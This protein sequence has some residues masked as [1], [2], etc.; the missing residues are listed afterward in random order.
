MGG[1]YPGKIV[2]EVFSKEVTF[3]S[4]LKDKKEKLGSGKISAYGR[5]EP[6]KVKG[7]KS[8]MTVI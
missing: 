3:Y 1:P 5:R 8:R 2:K 6:V 7:L 4:H